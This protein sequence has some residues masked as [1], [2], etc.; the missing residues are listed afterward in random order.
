MHPFTAIRARPQDDSEFCACAAFKLRSI[1]FVTVETERSVISP[2]P[3]ETPQPVACKNTA[4]VKMTLCSRIPGRERWQ[5]EV[6]EDRPR[7]AAALELVLGSEDG[8]ERVEANPLTGRVL[9][10][11]RPELISATIEELI[12]R[13]LEFGPMT[14]DE[15]A[16]RPRRSAGW[17]AGHLLAAEIACT[18]LKLTLFGGCCSLAL[19]AAGLL[20]FHHRRN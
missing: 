11:Y 1:K 15:Y 13:A 12:R 8:V 20:F 7:L 5:I 17:S 14:R 16:A 19:G 10:H 18:A 3:S 6:L 2:A 9:V 4:S